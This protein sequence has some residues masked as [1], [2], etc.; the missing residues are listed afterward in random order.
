[1]KSKISN[2]IPA[3]STV[4]GDADYYIA[5]EGKYNYYSQANV[6]W[7][8]ENAS[9]SQINPKY[10]LF[11]PNYEEENLTPETPNYI[12]QNYQQIAIIPQNKNIEGSPIT[13]CKKN[14]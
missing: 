13:I 12:N 3:N 7:F 6:V 9:F 8:N 10:L 11:N 4:L 2:Y 14:S 1:M 5:L